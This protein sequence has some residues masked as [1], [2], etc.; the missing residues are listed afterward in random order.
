MAG[1]QRADTRTCS[2][3]TYDGGSVE[4][5]LP[6]TAEPGVRGVGGGHAWRGATAA[7]A[8]AGPVDPEVSTTSGSGSSVPQPVTQRDDHVGG[9]AAQG[10]KAHATNASPPLRESFMDLTWRDLHHAELTVADLHDVL[11][12]RNRVFVVEQYV[13]LPGRRRARPGPRHPHPAR[14]SAA[15][16]RRGRDG[17]IVGYARLLAPY[18]GRPARIGRVIVTAEARGQRLGRRL[19]ERALVS[20]AEHWPDAGVEISAQAHLVDF[21]N[22]L[23]F[24]T[25]SAVYDDD[26]IPH[27]DMRLT[28]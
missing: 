25:T 5:P 21:Y 28:T 3:A 18:D 12:L 24:V 9:A 27:V 8:W 23:G 6:R 14:S 1:Q 7:P 15:T 4:Q 20:C 19:M 22:G 26:G 13:L 17:V 16:L 10:T 2:P 11:A